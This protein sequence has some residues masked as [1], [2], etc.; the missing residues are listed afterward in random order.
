MIAYHQLATLWFS[1]R[2]DT[3]RM[4]LDD[5]TR[6]SAAARAV[7][8]ALYLA[9]LAVTFSTPALPGGI[10]MP[11]IFIGVCAG[12]LLPSDLFDWMAAN[13]VHAT[14]L[15]VLGFTAL[16]AGVQH[17][18]VS[19]VIIITEGTG[20]SDLLIPIIVATIFGKFSAS[21]LQEGCTS[22]RSSS[23]ASRSSTTTCR[24]GS[25]RRA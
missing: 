3:I 24:S 4:L 25:T 1:D 22:S 17:S 5:P 9:L 15:A 16:L 11:L 10:F 7:S 12:G 18:S 21:L 19:L 2:E 6:F 23:R 13:D 8:A 14:T 20:R